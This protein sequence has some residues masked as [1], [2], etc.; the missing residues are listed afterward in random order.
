MYRVEE[1]YYG[2][3]SKD[4]VAVMVEYPCN[5]IRFQVFDNSKLTAAPLRFHK[6]DRPFNRSGYGKKIP[7]PFKVRF[8]GRLYRIYHHV[9]RTSGRAFIVYKGRQ[10][11]IAY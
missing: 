2:K 3:L 1:K 7:T 8:R 10:C 9:T 11:S 4:D 5:E 6:E